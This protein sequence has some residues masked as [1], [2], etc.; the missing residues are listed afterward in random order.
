MSNLSNG[1]GRKRSKLWTGFLINFK[2]GKLLTDEIK[3]ID[4]K[5]NNIDWISP[6]I[7]DEFK[8]YKLNQAQ[9]L[10]KLQIKKEDLKFWPDGGPQWDAIG[11]ANDNT[12]ILVEAK[13]N[14]QETKTKCTASAYKDP[15]KAS[16]KATDNL[17][18]IENAF[19][20]IINDCKY[21]ES[22]LNMW[23][24]EYYQLANRLVFL[25]NLNE[26]GYS[27][28][29]VLLNIANDFTYKKVSFEEWNNHYK[30]ILQK[31]IG[32]DKLPENVMTIFFDVE[33]VKSNA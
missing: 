5:I 32:S 16:E 19:L 1:I 33:G 29:L 30:E 28:K 13:G 11:I 6:I 14:K 27:V 18:L 2:K 17:L 25:H 23:F 22:N 8:E 21:D 3:K 26:K 20:K 9:I 24:D 4:E 7:D 10:K 12:I 31:M 15:K